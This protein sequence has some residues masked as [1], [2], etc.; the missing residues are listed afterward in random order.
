MLGGVS[1]ILAILLAG[2]APAETPPSIRCE[3]LCSVTHGRFT[4]LVA[5]RWLALVDIKGASGDQFTLRIS[6]SDKE[7]DISHIF[8][9]EL[10]KPVLVERSLRWYGRI[11][12]SAAWQD[13]IRI[14]ERA[15]AIA[16]DHCGYQPDPSPNS[17][18]TFSFCVE[19]LEGL[20]K[21]IR[22]ARKQ[23]AASK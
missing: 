15:P 4:F 1:V 9:G 18:T 8:S 13:I 10:S 19:N 2:S 14:L 11:L 5:K 3:T 12:R 22:S 17:I 23:L 20:G 7:L 21:A 16:I 6:R